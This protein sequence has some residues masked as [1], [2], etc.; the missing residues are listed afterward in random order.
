MKKRLSISISVGLCLV[1]LLCLGCSALGG[2]RT[3]VTVPPM[4]RAPPHGLISPKSSGSIVYLQAW[5]T[6]S[7]RGVQMSVINDTEGDYELD[8]RPLCDLSGLEAFA[9]DTEGKE[10]KLEV[11]QCSATHLY[12]AAD[13][14][15]IDGF[16]TLVLRPH[17]SFSW[18]V[19][20]Q[21]PDDGHRGEFRLPPFKL[22]HFQCVLSLKIG[23]KLRSNTFE[24]GM[25]PTLTRD[26]GRPSPS[27]EFSQFLDL[28]R[29]ELRQDPGAQLATLLSFLTMKAQGLLSEEQFAQVLKASL[30]AAYPLVRAHAAAF[31]QTWQTLLL[32]ADPRVRHEAIKA[33]GGPLACQQ[34]PLMPILLGRVQDGDPETRI[35]ALKALAIH[36]GGGIG[37]QFQETILRARSDPD[38]TVAETAR[39]LFTWIP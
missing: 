25:R 4:L 15:I 7:G 8:A 16:E 30:E 39:K 36:T 26:Q 23:V 33:A 20:I 27:K 18:P 9:V 37:R 11:S 2:K 35:L 24:L 13:K 12:G 21:H 28:F 31:P 29:W 17:Q 34:M 5:P 14:A 3:S 1:F 22:A 38:P 19:N 6:L 32:D 10:H